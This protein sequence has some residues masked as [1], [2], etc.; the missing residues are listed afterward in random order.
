MQLLHLMHLVSPALPIGAYA[1]SQGLESAIDQ[2]WI[3]GDEQIMDW[4]DNVLCHGVAQLDAAVLM[5]CQTAIEADD[6]QGLA[7][8]NNWL[9]ACRE[10]RELQLEDQQMGLAL[11]RLLNSLGVAR[12]TD[13][14]FASKP[15]YAGQFALACAHWQI[16]PRDAVYGFC[17]SW[18]EN[19]VA[20]ATKIVPLGQT[21]AQIMLAH[22][23]ERIP[24]ACEIA[25]TVDD[26]DMGIS[27]PGVAMASAQHEH[28][29]S[30]LFRS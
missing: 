1:Y 7:Y 30:R 22:L 12:A 18:L 16:S 21:Q 14:A 2:G 4:L 20:A 6:W 23:I 3:K 17:W 29:Y 26:S 9:S 15:T 11:Q 24:R 10:T 25:F 13:S 5:R 19:Q 8:W 28:Q 27:L